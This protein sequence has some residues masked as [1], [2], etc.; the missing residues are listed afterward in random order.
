MSHTFFGLFPK[1]KPHEVRCLLV[2]DKTVRKGEGGG[3]GGA[4]CDQVKTTK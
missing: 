4:D 1:T 2:A 3:E